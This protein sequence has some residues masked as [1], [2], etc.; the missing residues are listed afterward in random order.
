[1][2][3]E[4]ERS[5]QLAKLRQ[6]VE[7][8]DSRTPGPVE[9]AIG[10]YTLLHDEHPELTTWDLVCFA[11]YWL[12]T[13]SSEFQW[14]KSGAADIA[15]LVSFAHYHMDEAGLATELKRI[16]APEPTAPAQEDRT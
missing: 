16:L 3:D 7:D 15:K 1:M 5:D 13:M 8:R 11:A 12:V 4:V 6:L 9:R 2:A 14:L 10:V